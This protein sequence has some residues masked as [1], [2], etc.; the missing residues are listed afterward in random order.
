MLLLNQF[1]TFL[2]APLGTALL[3]WALAGAL[4]LK[5]LKRSARVLGVL[6]FAWLWYWS[7]PLARDWLR[8]QLEALSPHLPMTQVP[9]AQAMV[10][11]GGTMEPPDAMRPWPNWGSAAD[12]VWTPGLRPG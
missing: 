3:V 4:S 5:V 9:T 12:R 8:G 7:T 1:I 10:V 2:I 11:L 6:A